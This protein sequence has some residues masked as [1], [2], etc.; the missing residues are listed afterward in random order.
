MKLTQELKKEI[1]GFTL[2][3]IA[4]LFRFFPSDY[5]TGETGKYLQEKAKRSQPEKQISPPPSAGSP[6]L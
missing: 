3:K 2:S 1:D 4:S 5:T 6:Q